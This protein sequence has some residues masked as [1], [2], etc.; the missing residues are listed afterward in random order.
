M[1]SGK[2][3]LLYRFHGIFF[4]FFLALRN[5]YTL[6]S[7]HSLRCLRRIRERAE[8]DYTADGGAKVLNPQ[9]AEMAT[10][11]EKGEKKKKKKERK[12]KDSSCAK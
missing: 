1:V 5:S 8:L 12:G 7:L 6:A 4:S 9:A 11:K 2:L 3:L 10:A